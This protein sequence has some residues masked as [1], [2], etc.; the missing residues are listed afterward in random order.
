MLTKI[1]V[2]AGAVAV[3]GQAIADQSQYARGAGVAPDAYSTADV[4]KMRRIAEDGTADG[5]EMQLKRLK[6]H[7][8]TVTFATK[9][10]PGAGRAA[11]AASAG[12][13]PDGATGH[14]LHQ[15]VKAQEDREDVVVKRLRNEIAGIGTTPSGAGM[16][17]IARSLGVDPAGYSR[18]ELIRRFN[19]DYDDDHND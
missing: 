9:D 14:Q 15:L 13:S 16:A 19:A 7:L 18:D 11:L 10:A 17:Q 1:I 8:T 2:I 12:V 3:A 5:G 6:A 4:Q